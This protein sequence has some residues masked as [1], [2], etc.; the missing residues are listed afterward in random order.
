MYNPMPGADK[1][2]ILIVEDH[3]LVRDALQALIS[4]M[5]GLSVIGTATNGKE[6][7]QK[8]KSDTKPDVVLLDQDM[9]VLTGLET[10]EII[11]KDFFGIKVI[12]L[13]MMNTLDLVEAAIE[14]NVD[15]FLFKN[16][17]PDEL[18]MA[19]HQVVQ[20]QRYFTG[21]VAMILANKT[22]KILDHPLSKLSE[23]EIEILKLIAK[24]QTSVEIGHHLFI[25]PRTVDTHRNNIIQKIEVNGIAGLT[26][27]AIK[28][29]LVT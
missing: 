25:S 24:G 17:S 19:I 9:P 15:G 4:S 23:R 27:F 26:E 12:L 29:K 6:A 13:T 28:N 14:K 16:A 5:T 10:L 8:I 18:T 21:E 20:G 22:K 7:I 3:R 1:I 11:K 2:K